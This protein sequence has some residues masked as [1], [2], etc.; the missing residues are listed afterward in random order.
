MEKIFILDT[1]VILHS[2]ASLKS[3]GDNMVVIPL[4]VIEELD[5]FKK[6][7]SE[8]GRNAR[9]AIRQLD[10]LR[11]RGRLSDGVKMKNG[12]IFKISLTQP[13]E[14]IDF[15]KNITDNKILM[16]AYNLHRTNKDKKVI[17]VSKDIN[18][19]I[20]S[21]ALGIYTVDFEKQKVDF[22][23]LYTG[24]QQMDLNKKNY[25]TLLATG[26]MPV[27]GRKLC[28]NEYVIAYNAS[29]KEDHVICKHD[30]RNNKLVVLP[31]DN[32]K[33]WNIRPRSFEQRIA[34]DLLLDPEIKLVTLVGQAG[35]GKTLLALTVGLQ[36]VINESKFQKMLISR[37]IMPLGKDIGYL[38]GSKEEK[39]GHWMDPIHDNLEYIL[40]H[41][42]PDIKV[43]IYQ[44]FKDNKIETEALTYI[45]G[46]SI[47]NQFVII[48][49]AQNLTPHEIK[50]IISRAGYGTKMILTGDPY[51][52]DNPYLDAS[53]NG[54]SYATERLKDESL[55][56]TVTLTKS[57]RSPLASIAAELL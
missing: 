56:G 44:L 33:L 7:S 29:S 23:K 9:A 26:E 14:K 49:E 30:H 40:S 1:N 48:D 53:S 54:L 38:P 42:T 10:I 20:K 28:P 17:F 34:F 41:K 11:K 6:E 3:F 24:W 21:D 31:N 4:E 37:P 35:T 22:E 8:R 55:V 2:A 47:P 25:D 46:R 16:L 43:K 15:D 36:Q 57:E 27:E 52:I 19:R 50:T 12:G 39:I 13:D 18:A 32:L 45:R 5:K 51:Q